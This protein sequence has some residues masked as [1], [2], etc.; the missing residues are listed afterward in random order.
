LKESEIKQREGAGVSI[1]IGRKT[2][3]CMKCMKVTHQKNINLKRKTW[4]R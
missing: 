3:N 2:L 1:I 4:S